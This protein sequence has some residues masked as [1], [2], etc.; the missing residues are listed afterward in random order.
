MTAFIFSSTTFKQFYMRLKYLKQYSDARKKQVELINKKTEELAFQRKTLEE[1]KSEKQVVLNQEQQQKQQLDQA[2]KEQQGIVNDL[3]KQ[4]QDLI[5]KIAAAKKQQENLNS[6][7]KRIIEEEIRLA[8]QR[9]GRKLNGRQ[10]FRSSIPL[11]P[12][13]AALQFFAGNEASFLGL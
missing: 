5:K 12:E 7:I 2:K 1:K 13:A 11:T 4:E 6:M 9:H 10:I 3:S 8:G